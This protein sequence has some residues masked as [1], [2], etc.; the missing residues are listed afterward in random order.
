MRIGIDACCWANRRGYGRFTRGVTTALVK[1]FPQHEFVLVMDQ[2]T[3]AEGEFPGGATVEVV[4]TRVQPT[5]AAVAES[6]RSPADLWRMSRS[7]SRLRFDGFFFPTRYSFYPLFCRTP[8]VVAFHDATSE[9]MPGLLFP[10]W[11]S[12]MFWRLKTRLALRRA[13]RLVTVS[14]H[15]RKQISAAFGIP[16]E[17]IP[18][19]T[20]G[21]DA[22]FERTVGAGDIGDVLVRYR[23]PSDMPLL[24][25]VGGINPHKNLDG[26]LRAAAKLGDSGGGRCHVVLVGDYQDDGFHGCYGQLKD[27]ARALKIDSRVTF[28]GYVPDADL[29]RLYHAATAVVLPSFNEGFGLPVV[30]AMACGTPVVASRR[31]SLPEVLG[32]AG[33][34]FDPKNVDEMAATLGRVLADAPLRERMREAGSQQAHRY[35]WKAGAGRL[36]EVFE[37]LVMGRIPAMETASAEA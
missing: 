4:R 19:I 21:P 18:V 15:S 6:Y 35:S 34:Y 16:A 31:G 11:R 9:L 13:D 24:L 8:A 27:L 25:Y 10:N 30:E 37:E 12:R 33:A 17:S 23:I 7:V 1:E 14:E 20:E 3:A 26:L 2:R 32:T 36:V 29:A 28:T 5:R 22:V